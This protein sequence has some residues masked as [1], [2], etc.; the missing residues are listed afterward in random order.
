MVARLLP[1]EVEAKIALQFTLL[2][3]DAGGGE[4]KK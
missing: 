1:R 4:F 3:I 2:D